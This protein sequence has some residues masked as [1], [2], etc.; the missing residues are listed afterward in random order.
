M[1]LQINLHSLV[2]TPATEIIPVLTSLVF[3]FN[4]DEGSVNGQNRTK[5]DYSN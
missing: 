4:L 1:E 5:C 3:H 2:D